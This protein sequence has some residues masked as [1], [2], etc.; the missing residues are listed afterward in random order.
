MQWVQWARRRVV[1]RAMANSGPVGRGH[2]AEQCV[3]VCARKELL[4]VACAGAKRLLR[5]RQ[6]TTPLRGQLLPQQPFGATTRSQKTFE[7][8]LGG[9][10]A[11]RQS[12]VHDAT[13]NRTSHGY[14]PSKVSYEER[15]METRRGPT[16]FCGTR[17]TLFFVFEEKAPI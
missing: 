16:R 12:L 3:H 14:I 11:N 4:C 10:D 17:G 5:P 1:V 7:Q 13:A 9:V 6:A 8:N 15:W 2:P